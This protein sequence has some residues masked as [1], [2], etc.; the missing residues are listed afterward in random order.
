MWH[1]VLLR[2]RSSAG[3]PLEKAGALLGGEQ[4]SEA[5]A[6]SRGKPPVQR[7]VGA[8]DRVHVGAVYTASGKEIQ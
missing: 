8:F 6:C 7:M 5:A 2:G 1:T 4:Q 3:K